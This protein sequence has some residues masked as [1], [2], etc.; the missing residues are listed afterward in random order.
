MVSFLPSVA[1]DWDASLSGSE[2]E[3]DLD[4]V[5]ASNSENLVSVLDDSTDVAFYSDSLVQLLV[6]VVDV[7]WP[8]VRRGVEDCIDHIGTYPE[9][10]WR[11]RSL[12]T[13]HAAKLNIDRKKW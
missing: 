6:V 8:F 13:H 3:V 12:H 10:R 11:H 7:V 5:P 4:S 1:A 9:R 2:E